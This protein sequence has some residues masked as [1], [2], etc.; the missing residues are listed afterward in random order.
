MRYYD[1]VRAEPDGDMKR[2][3]AELGVELLYNLKGV[4]EVEGP[5]E[6]LKLLHRARVLFVKKVNPTLLSLASQ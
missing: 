4:Y 2:V 5:Q 1:F 6:G 3:A